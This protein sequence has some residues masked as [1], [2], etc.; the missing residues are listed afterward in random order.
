MNP[1]EKMPQTFDMNQAEL[2]VWAILLARDDAELSDL[3]GLLND[4]E[5]S[6]AVRFK[7]EKDRKNYVAAHG[8]LRRIL[9]RYLQTAPENLNFEHNY[10]GKPFLPE[11]PHNIEFNLAHSSDRALVAVAKTNAVGVD[12]ERIRRAFASLDIAGHYFSPSEYDRLRSLPEH[13]HTKVFFDC[14]TRK[15]AFIKAVGQG[16]SYPLKNFEVTVA[17]D[18]AAKLLTVNDSAVEALRWQ[19]FDL[20]AGEHFSAAVAIES[21]TA[22]DLKFYKWQLENSLRD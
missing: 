20:N 15:E 8:V 9:G 4:E 22:V 17:P 11:N 21:G 18:E 16:L 13:L 7:F 5:K 3:Y 2:H 1:C 12:I 14:W 6:K 10:Y 19:L